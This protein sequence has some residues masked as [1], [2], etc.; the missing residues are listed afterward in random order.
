MSKYNTTSLYR[1][2]TSKNDAVRANYTRGIFNRT[3]TGSFVCIER[4]AD[5]VRPVEVWVKCECGFELGWIAVDTVEELEQEGGVICD[6]CG[7]QVKGEGEMYDVVNW[8]DNKVIRSFSKLSEAKK[9]C[10]SLGHLPYDKF[11]T[12]YSPIARVDNSEGFT[13]YNPRF[14][15]KCSCCGKEGKKMGTVQLCPT[16]YSL[17]CED[18]TDGKQCGCCADQCDK[19]GEYTEVANRVNGQLLCDKCAGK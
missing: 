2:W 3:A 4:Q 16:C 14:P 1:I 11:T 7:K 18:C 17:V 13:V 8:D 5:A 6:A 9:F 19:C 15:Y 12:S 10:R